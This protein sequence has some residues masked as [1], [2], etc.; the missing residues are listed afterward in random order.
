MTLLNHQAI[1]VS[2]LVLLVMISIPLSHAKCDFKAIFNFGDSNSDTGGFHSAFPYLSPSSSPPQGMTYFKK[3]NGRYTDGRLYLDFLSQALGLPFLNPFLNT[4]SDFKHGVNFAVSASS[5]L[6]PNTSLFVNG[7]SPF[8]LDV[9]INQMKL[10]KSRVEEYKYLRTNLPQPDIFKKALYTIFIGQHDMAYDFAAVGS[11]GIEHFEPRIALG[12]SNAIKELYNLGGRTF[13]VFNLPPVGC[14]AA[15][16][17][18]ISHTSSE[19]DSAGCMTFLNKA[20]SEYNSI[21]NTTLQR[22]RQDHIDAKIIYTDIYSVLYKL[23]HNPTAHGMEHSIKACCGYGGGKYN[24]N[25]DVF[26][27]TTEVINGEKATASACSDPEKYVSWDGIHHTETVNKI[28]A[29]AILSGNIF[30]PGFS[31]HQNCD[32]QPIG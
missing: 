25:K 20:I 1:V 24:F 30:H 4:V 29:E 27:G 23:Y 26:C 21:L 28:M 2:W 6:Q 10:F 14:Y 12:I 8:Y 13:L 31:F 22:T 32:I 7:E 17:T 3:P 18:Q 5:V 16:L 15:A 11:R 19:L 9:Q